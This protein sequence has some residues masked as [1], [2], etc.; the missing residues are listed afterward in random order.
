[1]LYDAVCHANLQSVIRYRYPIRIRGIVENDTS[2]SIR[3]RK[4]SR[5]S[6]NNSQI[7][8]CGSISTHLWSRYYSTSNNLQMAQ[9]RAYS[10]NGGLTESHTRSIKPRHFQ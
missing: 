1:M 5:I 3:I 2:V 6:A 8:I 7:S 10:Y 9:D 4:N